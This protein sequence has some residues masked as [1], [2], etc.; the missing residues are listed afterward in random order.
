MSISGLALSRVSHQAFGA[1]EA[2]YV[3]VRARLCAF[4]CVHMYFYVIPVILSSSASFSLS[5]CL[6]HTNTHTCARTHVPARRVQVCDRLGILGAGHP[7]SVSPS[8]PSS[9]LVRA[10]GQA[11]T[12]IC[13][14]NTEISQAHPTPWQKIAQAGPVRAKTACYAVSTERIYL[15]KRRPRTCTRCLGY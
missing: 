12:S 2:A 5:L 7:L 15:P 11:A 8:A 4:M 9:K 13:L 1:L 6:R 10:R 14:V 3:C